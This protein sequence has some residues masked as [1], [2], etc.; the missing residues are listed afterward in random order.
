MESSTFTFKNILISYDINEKENTAE[1]IADIIGATNC[2][3]TTNS[4]LPDNNYIKSGISYRQLSLNFPHHLYYSS[5]VKKSLLIQYKEFEQ[6]AKELIK[7]N[8]TSLMTLNNNYSI[9]Q[10]YNKIINF[11]NQLFTNEL[12]LVILTPTPHQNY[13]YFFMMFAKKNNIKTIFI[14]IFYQIEHNTIMQFITSEDSTLDTHH[15]LREMEYSKSDDLIIKIKDKNHLLTYLEFFTNLRII[16]IHNKRVPIFVEY[17][18]SNIKQFI[19]RQSELML[20]SIKNLNIIYLFLKISFFFKRSLMDFFYQIKSVWTIDYYNRNSYKSEKLDFLYVYFPLHFQPEATTCPAGG[21]YSNQI[22]AVE[23]LR[24]KLD[25]NIIILVK[26]HPAY[27]NKSNLKYYGEYRSKSYYKKLLKIKNTKLIDFNLDSHLL[28][29]NSIAVSTITGSV[30]LESI[31]FNKFCIV[32]GTTILSVLKNVIRFED[33]SESTL[34]T[35][36]IIQNE[37]IFQNSFISLLLTIDSVSSKIDNV[38]IF[39]NSVDGVKRYYSQVA[40]YTAEN[41]YNYLL[42]KS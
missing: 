4:N 7:R 36:P 40:K 9:N 3:Y 41:V 24:T 20:N 19:A 5:K 18:S 33:F 26:E 11:V 27:L 23:A 34:K 39:L 31:K 37:P 35:N 14:N 38:N 2:I 22:L 8:R 6:T 42:N 13:D 1:A 29:E 32:F 16:S 25:E 15:L 10:T 21:I 30:I 12:D 28:I 17:K